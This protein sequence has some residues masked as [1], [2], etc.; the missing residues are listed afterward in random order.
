MSFPHR[1]SHRSRQNLDASKNRFFLP[2]LVLADSGP[3]K[4]VFQFRASNEPTQSTLPAKYHIPFFHYFG[5]D[6]AAC[7]CLHSPL[8]SFARSPAQST[9]EWFHVMSDSLSTLKTAMP[10]ISKDQCRLKPFH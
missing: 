9:T 6:A 10:L 7:L 8:C 3:S 4:A 2:P 1:C 5:F